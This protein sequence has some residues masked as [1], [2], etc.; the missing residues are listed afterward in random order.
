MLV[1]G[2]GGASVLLLPLGSFLSTAGSGPEIITNS[3]V[4][5]LPLGSFIVD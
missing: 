2:L 1:V 3:E 4:L 5:L